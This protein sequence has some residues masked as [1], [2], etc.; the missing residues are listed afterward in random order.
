MFHPTKVKVEST[1]LVELVGLTTIHASA[2]ETWIVPEKKTE[3]R[4][5]AAR[6]DYL[7]GTV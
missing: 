7:P 5:S 3:N 6:I 4:V 1:G 2:K